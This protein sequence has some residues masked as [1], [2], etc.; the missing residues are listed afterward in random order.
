PREGAAGGRGGR[1]CAQAAGARPG[2]PPPDR[3]APGQRRNRRRIGPSALLTLPTTDRVV[4]PFAPDDDARRNVAKLCAAPAGNTAYPLE[5]L[6]GADRVTL[7]EDPFG[8]LDD[9]ARVERG[10][11]LDRPFEQ[12]R[13]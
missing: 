1:A 10:L 4:D 6:V 9:D 11:Q 2:P 8:L 7:G 5:R 12:E 13:S 3:P